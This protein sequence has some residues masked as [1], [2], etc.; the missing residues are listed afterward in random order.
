MP[1]SFGR[2]SH[3]RT[4][5]QSCSLAS[6]EVV[7]LSKTLFFFVVVVVVVFVVVVVVFN[8]V[9]LGFVLFRQFFFLPGKSLTGFIARNELAYWTVFPR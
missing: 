7:E 9:W 2:S 5:S 6:P 4:G 3:D 8:A 1:L